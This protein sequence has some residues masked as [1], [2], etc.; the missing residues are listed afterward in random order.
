MQADDEMGRSGRRVLSDLAAEADGHG[1]PIETTLAEGQPADVLLDEAGDWPADLLAVG[2]EGHGALAR[3]IVGSVA[4][5]VVRSAPRPVLTVRGDPAKPPTA[6]IERVVVPTD[7]SA[8]SR[9]AAPFAIDLAASTGAR[10]DLL[11]AIPPQLEDAAR[12]DRPAA[13]TRQIREEVVEAALTPLVEDCRQA[14]VDHERVVRRARAREAIAGYADE[15][16]VDVIVMATHGRSGVERF[17]LASVTDKVIR[18]T[19]T[20]VVTIRPGDAAWA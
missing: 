2:T 4:D 15:T 9:A 11:H 3:A 16:D 10:V 19:D 1:V 8:A 7:G 20:P 5:Q 17:L 14:G 13:Q 12:V 6:P 18:S